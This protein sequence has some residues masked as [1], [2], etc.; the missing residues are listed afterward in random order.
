VP[1]KHGALKRISFEQ[2]Y[3]SDKDIVNNAKQK[4]KRDLKQAINQYLQSNKGSLSHWFIYL[5]NI[6]EF[7]T[8]YSNTQIIFFSCLPYW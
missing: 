1:P 4:N 5:L 6:F 2:D 7:L 3:N 8:K